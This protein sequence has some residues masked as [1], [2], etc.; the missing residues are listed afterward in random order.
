MKDKVYQFFS[1]AVVDKFIS[2]KIASY[3]IIEYQES[4]EI[5]ECIIIRS[6]R[7]LEAGKS[8][9][10]IRVQIVYIGTSNNCDGCF[11]TL[12]YSAICNF[13]PKNMYFKA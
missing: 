7:K 9:L 1:H 10:G 11:Y 5:S 4:V 12:H 3:Y 6:C 8:S 2:V 13:L